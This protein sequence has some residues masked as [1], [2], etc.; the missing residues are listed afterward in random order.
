MNGFLV[1][2]DLRRS[3]L[4]GGTHLWKYRREIFPCQEAG[5]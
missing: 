2:T 1:C 4:E 3:M 5:E